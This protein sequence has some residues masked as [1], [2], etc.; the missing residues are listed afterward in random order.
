MSTRAAALLFAAITVFAV[1]CAQPGAGPASPSS[2]SVPS[3][4]AAGPGADYIATGWW[5]FVTTDIHGNVDEPPF[6]TYVTQDG[7]GNLHF[8]DE[9]DAPITLER[10]G[11]GVILTYRLSITGEEGGGCDIRVQGTVRLDTTTNT[12]TGN[13]RLKQLGCDNGRQGVVVIGRMLN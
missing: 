4:A 1:S 2:V 3:A 12:L 7:D 8:L 13:I 6:D 9:D 10:L 5:R 11:T